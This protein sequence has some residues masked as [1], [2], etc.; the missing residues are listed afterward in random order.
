MV[1]CAVWLKTMP[2]P[3]LERPWCCLESPSVGLKYSI[4]LPA[5]QFVL[6]ATATAVES[7]WSHICWSLYNLRKTTS[8]F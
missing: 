7:W 5:V 3:V 8:Q 1:T 6:R 2:R 4:Q